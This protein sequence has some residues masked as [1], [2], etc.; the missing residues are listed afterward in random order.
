MMNAEKVSEKQAF[1]DILFLLSSNFTCGLNVLV[2][3]IGFIVGRRRTATNRVILL[4]S[5]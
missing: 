5:V 2:I 4:R 3:I 1:I